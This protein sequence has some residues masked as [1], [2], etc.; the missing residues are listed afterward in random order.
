MAIVKQRYNA[1]EM[2]FQQEL[3]AA[4]VLF[5]ALEVLIPAASDCELRGAGLEKN[6]LENDDF[7]DVGCNIVKTMLSPGGFNGTNQDNRS[8]PT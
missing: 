1:H 3:V 2:T 5:N 6:L 7:H 4:R 8:P